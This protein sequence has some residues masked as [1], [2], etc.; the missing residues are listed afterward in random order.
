M[1][2]ICNKKC[3]RKWQTNDW[4]SIIL[5]AIEWKLTG[6]QL[7]EY[8]SKIDDF[9]TRLQVVTKFVEVNEKFC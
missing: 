9:S 6:N 4:Q 8:V 3:R 7:T 5:D 1:Q 2:R